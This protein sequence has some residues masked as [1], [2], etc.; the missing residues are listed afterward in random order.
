MFFDSVCHNNMTRLLILLTQ[1]CQPNSAWK[2]LCQSEFIQNIPHLVSA[3]DATK[4][5]CVLAEAGKKPTKFRS[6]WDLDPHYYTRPIKVWHKQGPTCV[7]ELYRVAGLTCRHR[8]QG[9]LQS[10]CLAIISRRKKNPNV[11]NT[12]Y[13]VRNFLILKNRTNFTDTDS[14]ENLT[15]N[16]RCL[17]FG[18]CFELSAELV[19]GIRGLLIVFLL[20]LVTTSHDL[21]RRVNTVFTELYN[22]SLTGPDTSH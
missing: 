4:G 16:M 10:L 3:S 2:Y 6:E 17:I 18:W 1:P 14:K 5:V 15:H 21:T 19:W 11:M 12:N 22:G 7:S 20:Y 13:R 8:V 9:S